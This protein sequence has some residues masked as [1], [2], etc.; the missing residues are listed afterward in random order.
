MWRTAA[1][2]LPFPLPAGL[3]GLLFIALLIT[4]HSKNKKQAG[5]IR[6]QYAAN[7]EIHFK[8]PCVVKRL[9]RGFENEG[10]GGGGTKKNRL[11]K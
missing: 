2:P 1:M 3:A 5:S 4:L 8:G 10:E 7:A 11:S 9:P 6:Q